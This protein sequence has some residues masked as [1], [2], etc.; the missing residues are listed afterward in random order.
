[1]SMT[2]KQ[3]L[4]GMTRA[5][6]SFAN[7]GIA[8]AG[9]TWDQYLPKAQPS[10]DTVRLTK[11]ERLKGS[12]AIAS[13]IKDRAKYARSLAQRPPANE[14]KLRE[15]ETIWE[16]IRQ[17]MSE[18]PDVADDPKVQEFLEAA[19]S[20]SGASIDLLTEEVRVWLHKNNVAAKYRITTM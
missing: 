5:L 4:A 18:L 8:V 10:V 11:A 6:N 15:I 19:E 13:R 12:V 17:M 9:A 14:E 2:K 7:K 16:D 1:L 3:T 20:R